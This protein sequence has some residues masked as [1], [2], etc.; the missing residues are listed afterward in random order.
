MQGITAIE[1]SRNQ[2]RREENLCEADPSAA[3][4]KRRSMARRKL[5]DFFFNR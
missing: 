5:P 1:D 3:C 2:P 4:E